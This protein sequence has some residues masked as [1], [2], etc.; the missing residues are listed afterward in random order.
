LA[1]ALAA[2]RVDDALI[3]LAQRLAADLDRTP[4]GDKAASPF[5][6]QLFA[7]LR[8][9]KSGQVGADTGDKLADDVAALR[10]ARGFG[11]A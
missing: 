11:L 7:V 1:K 8:E 4:P 5:A 6:G 9:L 2:G 10:A 3:A